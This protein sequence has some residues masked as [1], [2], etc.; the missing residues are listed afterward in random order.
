MIII[1]SKSNSN[2]ERKTIILS[3][4]LGEEMKEEG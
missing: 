1:V 3:A 2:G 4:M